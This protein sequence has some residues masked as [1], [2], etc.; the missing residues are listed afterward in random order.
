MVRRLHGFILFLAVTSS[1]SL[2]AQEQIFHLDVAQS[3]ADFTLGDV[4][5]TVH[6]TFKL[7]SGELRFDSKTGEAS[8]QLILDATTGNSGNGTRDKKMKREILETD[9]Y[10]TIVFTPQKVMGSVAPAGA[11]QVQ[12]QGS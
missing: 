6:G 3:H 4:L 1:C 2:F 12:M 10:P 7:S 5:H 9:K 11:S 8:G